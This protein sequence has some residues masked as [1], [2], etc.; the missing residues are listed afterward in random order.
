MIDKNIQYIVKIAECKSILKASESLGITTS[1]LSK[2]V[3]KVESDYGI[4]LFQRIGKSFQLTYA[5][6][7][8]VKWA[9]EIL[10]AESS[11]N[12]DMMSIS[13]QAAN[14]ISIGTTE[15]YDEIIINQVLP[16]FRKNYPETEIQ[17]I[18]RTRPSL[19]ND[20][21]EGKL[22]FLVTIFGQIP[23]HCFSR[24]IGKEALCLMAGN[25]S[26]LIHRA[27][28]KPGRPYP[29]IN[30]TD[31][32]EEDFISLPKG[33]RLRSLLDM[34]FESYGREPNVSIEVT[35]VYD[36]LQF[37]SLDL[38]LGINYPS[39]VSHDWGGSITP[40]SFGDEPI[41][42]THA[43]VW[44]PGHLG[45]EPFNLMLDLCEETLKQS[46]SF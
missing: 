21:T 40:L 2:A 32:L 3:Q 20:L 30:F 5:G 42:S 14:R 15:V 12:K 6:Q 10:R 34:I 4:H 45:T 29:W 27:V 41:Y 17:I 31:I 1:T 19:L 36:M 39:L 22:D 11:M 44:Q 13:R 16:A 28:E 26:D 7:R 37:V 38:G 24:E 25:G 8:Y 23:E 33:R 43:I 18:K 35:N 9:E 46:L